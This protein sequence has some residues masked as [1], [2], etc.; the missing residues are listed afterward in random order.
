MPTCGDANSFIVDDPFEMDLILDQVI[1]L[2][3][4]EAE[5]AEKKTGGGA[6]KKTAA[7]G[8]KAAEADKKVEVVEPKLVY[9]ELLHPNSMTQAYMNAI[10]AVLIRRKLLE[11]IYES[12]IA[13][14]AYRGQACDRR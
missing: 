1:V 6:K 12:E 5:L 10:E 7:G 9:N 14:A 11:S 8:G 13:H 2:F 4:Y 3:D